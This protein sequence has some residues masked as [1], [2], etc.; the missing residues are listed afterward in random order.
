MFYSLLWISWLVNHDLGIR[1]ISVIAP[2]SKCGFILHPNCAPKRT[3]YSPVLL[4]KATA[5]TDYFQM[6]R[7]LRGSTRK[8]DCA[9]PEITG[10]SLHGTS[11]ALRWVIPTHHPP[12]AVWYPTGWKIIIC[13]VAFMC[14]AGGSKR[15]FVPFSWEQSCFD[16]GWWS[17]LRWTVVLGYP[18]SVVVGMKLLDSFRTYQMQTVC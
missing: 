14:A 13:F 18:L 15:E 3:T 10:C 12:R 11:R 6:R 17:F 2:A 8:L 1:F 5:K 4:K 7:A 16:G 9:D